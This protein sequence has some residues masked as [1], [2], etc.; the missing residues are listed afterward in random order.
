MLKEL[1]KDNI[2]FTSNKLSWEEAVK[3]SAQPL[4]EKNLIKQSYIESIINSVKQQGFYI[5]ISP[6][7]AFPHARFPEGV[8]KICLSLLVSTEKIQFGANKDI[9]LIFC[10]GFIDD[11]SHMEMLQE[12]AT[13]L[14]N[15]DNIQKLLVAK[16]DT[17]VLSLL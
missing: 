5:V 6:E 8:N 11:N 9:K 2:I 7:I 4:L 12:L 17:D 10:V 14:S 1:L 3:V 15:E 16:Q 13:F